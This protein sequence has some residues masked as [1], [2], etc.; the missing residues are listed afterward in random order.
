MAGRMEVLL[1]A[2]NTTMPKWHMK[3]PML[4]ARQSMMQPVR[5]LMIPASSIQTATIFKPLLAI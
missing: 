2:A 4:S 1:S 5:L 3:S